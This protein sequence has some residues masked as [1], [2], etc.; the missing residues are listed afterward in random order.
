[1]TTRIRVVAGVAAATILLF[2]LLGLFVRHSHYSWESRQL[3]ISKNAF[4]TIGDS[5]LWTYTPNSTVTTAATY[6][7]SGVRGWLEYKCVFRTNH[8]G[9][10]DTNVEDRDTTA[11][12]L[13]LGDSYTEGHGGCPWLTRETLAG[14]PYTVINGGLQGFGLPAKLL[15]A[16]WLAPQ[17]RVRNVVVVAISN[18]FKRPLYPGMWQG[19]DR[20]LREGKCDPYADY[21]W[22]IDGTVSDDK[23][24]SLSLARYGSRSVP[25]PTQVKSTLG[26]YSFS[27]NVASRLVALFRGWTTAPRPGADHE[28]NFQNS[29]DAL[30]DL[31][32]RYPRLKVLLVPQRDEVGLLG[33]E[34]L[35]TQRIRGFLTREGFEFYSCPLAIGD[36]M[37]IDGHPNRAGYQKLM[38]CLKSLLP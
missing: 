27:Y 13:V 2:E 36:Y 11:D 28:A 9:L 37:P 29:Y 24:Y 6:H 26:Y 10:I 35:D 20:C 33:R 8:F 32:R 17:I 30:A 23:L 5:G 16:D 21:W 34:N 31:K 22:G 38:T 12:Y 1:M 3:F 4:R 15:L 18:D 14:A 7:L 25:V 19:R